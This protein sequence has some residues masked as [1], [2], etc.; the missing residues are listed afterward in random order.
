MISDDLYKI[1]SHQTLLEANIVQKELDYEVLN[2]N[3]CTKLIGYSLQK[4][5]K[6]TNVKTVR[7]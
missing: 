5:G 1:M 7:H 3:Q 6:Y 2:L 4:N